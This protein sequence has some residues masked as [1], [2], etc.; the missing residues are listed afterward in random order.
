MNA[1]ESVLDLKFDMIFFKCRSSVKKFLTLL[2]TR[3]VFKT[4]SRDCFSLE[5]LRLCM[6]LIN[7]RTTHI[8]IS[9]LY[10]YKSV[11]FLVSF[12]A[13][14]VGFLVSVVVVRFI[15]DEFFPSRVP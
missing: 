14:V 10:I 1:A 4:V 11:R 7:Y 6:D 2:G 13:C 8:L 12:A 3:S 9:S 5:V 15:L